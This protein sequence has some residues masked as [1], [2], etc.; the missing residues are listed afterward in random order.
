MISTI[1]PH[2]VEL[3][4]VAP[5]D[6]FQS[7]S[8]PLPTQAKVEAIQALID[9]GI[10]RIE[11]GSFVS[12]KAVPQMAD[13][14]DIVSAF[15]NQQG[16]RLSALIPNLKG[17]E[18]ALA[19]GLRELVYVVSVSETHNKK[20]VRQSVDAS[21]EGLAH[22]A[23]RVRDEGPKARLRLDLGTCFDCPYEGR[24]DAQRVVEVLRKALAVTEGL[25]L[26]VA[27]C[28]TTGRANPYQVRETLKIVQQVIGY[29]T[30]DWAF[31]GHNTFGAGVANALF[32]IEQGVTVLDASCA[33][34]GGCPFAPG[35]TGNTATEDLVFA[36][37]EGGIETGIDMMR[38]LHAADL[39]AALPGGLTASSLRQVPRTRAATR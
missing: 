13:I 24:I 5:R 9:A 28:D 1:P 8:D 22:I 27:F 10:K 33:G 20:N 18:L 29:D 12:P 31:H 35:A 38:L 23:D 37:Q 19:S 16:V 25:Q 11:I 26:E 21:L 32:A 4:E 34:L 3:V 39:I 36:L 14:K 17:A 7:I 2:S 6:G 30:I 15:I